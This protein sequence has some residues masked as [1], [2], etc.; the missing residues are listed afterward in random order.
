MVMTLVNSNNN[1][2]PEKVNKNCNEYL[3]N[4]KNIVNNA[5]RE[6]IENNI[7]TRLWNN[8]Y[9]IWKSE[10]TEISNRLGWLNAPENMLKNV[11]NL[12]NFAD[13]IQSNG[14][15]HALLLGM[16]GSS[17]APEV[18][19]QTFGVKSNYLDLAVLD[20]TDPGAVLHHS[21]SLDPA[22]TLYIVSTKSGG[23]VET[24][25]FLKYF[26]N[27]THGKLGK[28][29]VGNH[30]IAITDSGSLLEKIATNLNFRKI[31]LNDPN[32]GGRFSVLTYFGLVP[33]ALIGLDIGKILKTANNASKLFRENSIHNV[34]ARLGVIIGELAKQGQ[35]KLT[36]IIS[37]EIKYFGIWIEQLIAESTGK[38]GRGI[39]PVVG[40]EMLN[41]S[42]YSPDRVFV[43]IRLKDDY[44]FEQQLQSFVQE[45]FPVIQLILNDTYDLGKEFFLWEITT[46]I[47]GWR[48]AI[49]PFDQPNVESAKVMTQKILT[50]Y[51]KTGNI[52]TSEVT[53]E[54][55]GIKVYTNFKAKNI[56]NVFEKLFSNIQGGLNG[57]KGRSYISIQA[58]VKP[59]KEIE[60]ALQAFRTILLKKFQ[61]ATTLGFGP[62]F[63]HS[64]G[65]LH[66]GDAGNGIFIQFVST[67]SEDIPIPNEVDSSKSY[68]SFGTLKMAQCMGDA[69]ALK[70]NHRKIIR[71]DL[72]VDPIINLYKLN[73]YIQ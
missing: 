39:L 43:N 61:L 31:F 18:F 51:R 34:A 70:N 55:D 4:S 72:G 69:E 22:K 46:S 68:M 28:T 6:L 15:T 41:P 49:N 9:T 19:R 59:E 1:D 58:Y 25:S 11:Q 30:F 67:S 57:K 5:I 37:E 62:R 32:V 10:P 26:Y 47:A 65:Q 73:K 17:L 21:R 50:E 42:Q 23:T 12:K 16:G 44:T 14:F 8:D 53:V 56:S 40:E 20:S 48:L 33:A 66:K 27:H 24:L 2:E 35:D 52:P 38:E 60:K 45:G 3:G 54:E 29:E 7:I 64:T 13:E 36:F 71:I 63:L